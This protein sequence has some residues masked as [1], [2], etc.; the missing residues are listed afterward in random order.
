MRK[1]ER[2]QDMT[3]RP[4]IFPENLNLRLLS[5]AVLTFCFL[6]QALAEDYFDP[7]ALEVTGGQ[8]QTGDLSYFAEKGGQQPGTYKVTVFV[9]QQRVEERKVEFVDVD[10]Q[11]KPV[12]TVQYLASLGVNT[13]A[14][15]AFSRLH[16][17]ESFSQLDKY[18]SDATSKFDFT[19]QRLD[20]SIPQAAMLQKS[21]GYVPPEEWDE[22]IPA[23]FVDYNFSGSTTSIDD[24]HSNENY[25]NL[26][27]GV[28]IGAWRLR[29]NSSY[30]YDQKGRWQTQG[31][32]LQRD[33]KSLKSELTLGDTYTSGEVFDSVQFTGVQL[34]SDENMLPD[35]QRGF[36][37]TIRGIAHSNARITVRQHGY[38]IY[39]TYVAPGAFAINDLYPT[40]QSGDL[41]ITIRESDGSERKF[42]QPY[43]AVPF[44]LREG[45]FKY[46]FSAG[47]YTAADADS[48]EPNF[49]QTSAFYG[50]P[51]SLT[52][53]G[54]ALLSS[55]YQSLALG[56]GRDFGN[57]GSLGV[58]AMGANTD[59]GNDEQYRGQSIRTQYQKDF[60]TTD[61][62]ISVSNYHYSSRRFYE[63]S[64]AN[65]YRDPDMH[66][67]NR[68]SRTTLSLAQDFGVYGNIS[69]SLYRQQYWDSPATDQTIHL[70]YYNSYRGISWSVGYY[71]TR[72]YYDDD[73]ERSV[74]LN[75]SVPL[76]KWLPGGSV[77][78]SLTNNLDGHTTQQV[79]LY[80]SAMENDK[81]NYNIQQGF[82]NQNHAANSSLSLDYRSGYGDVTV[83]YSHDR[84]N[85]R[86][87]YGASGGIVATQ[88]GLTMSQ[89]LGDTMA[90][91]RAPGAG[92]VQIE[93]A[94]NVHT[95]SR[96]YAVV[97]NLSAYH[98]NDIS[99]DT[100]TLG[101]DI[102]L[103]QNSQFVV[104]TRGAVLLANYKT[105]IGA[106][107]MLT[108]TRQG[109]PLPFGA[110]AWVSSR[111]SKSG[112]GIVGSGGQVYLS[113]VPA[114]GIIH[115]SWQQDGQNYQCTA[116]LTLPAD[117]VAGSVRLLTATCQ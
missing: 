51:W 117:A 43:S 103:E 61:T 40:A 44:M 64:E 2:L 54:G 86:L 67:T 26:R 76:S 116:P 63:F 85:D 14:F 94:T 90:L 20:F 7:Q 5:G 21:R 88:Y 27:S 79:S 112:K 59:L 52:I 10:G 55:H 36:A 66:V 19:G 68:R 46:S 42:T 35:S 24:L 34:A 16:D 73:N 74:N 41:E 77:S 48:E 62:S 110:N 53:Y 47:R 4:R 12:L 1:K 100:Q 71:L 3:L 23:A 115:A 9:N 60:A 39:E 70:G 13:S 22:G 92:N 106:R 113:G 32:W 50:L 84:Y 102:D 91:V 45:R 114:Q 111:D 83:G 80:G 17:G 30:E 105:H 89:S 49:V 81:L 31:T 99:L 25:L 95:N 15:S 101:D 107:V 18:I 108:L 37:P 72:S 87:S 8:Q 11:L 56:L 65:S 75:I 78:Y 96:G 93:G 28:N 97:P 69:A 109:K 29:N 98:K 58:S 38:V 104:P 33:V 82:D 57:M 6:H